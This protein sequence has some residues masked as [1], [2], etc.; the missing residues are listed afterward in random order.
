MSLRTSAL[1]IRY[2]SGATDD[3]ALIEAKICR[4]AVN[5][6]RLAKYKCQIIAQR[7]HEFAREVVVVYDDTDDRSLLFALRVFDKFNS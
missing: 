5:S 2:M 4:D 1:T 3:E 7:F 6:D